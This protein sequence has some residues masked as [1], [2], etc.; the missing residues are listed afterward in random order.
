MKY[1]TKR[2]K[3]LKLVLKE[4]EPFV[5]NGD[6]LETGKPFK[7]FDGLRSREVLANCLLCIVIDPDRF[8]F[9]I[10][11]LGGDGIILD[12][13]TGE[14]WPTEHICVLNINGGETSDIETLILSAISKKQNKGGAAYASGKTLVVFLNAE[15]GKWFPN[16]IAKK[17]PE[18]LDFEAVWVVGLNGVDAG[19]YVYNVTRLDLRQGNAPAWQV[20]IGEDFNTWEVV[21]VQ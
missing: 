19:K 13:I 10:D 11:P 1:Q 2:V 12:K 15:G 21:S 20:C 5:R 4:L 17:L 6:H 3:N 18:K 14:T 9:A 7:Q 16:K 8:T